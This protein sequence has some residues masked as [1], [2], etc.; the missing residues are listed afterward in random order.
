VRKGRLGAAARR[1]LDFTDGIDRAIPV[2]EALDRFHGAITPFN[3]LNT[4]A[5]S[6][7]LSS[8]PPHRCGEFTEGV[9][10]SKVERSHRTHR[11][12]NRKLLATMRITH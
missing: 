4:L 5:L 6:T 9:E 12:A 2:P 10:I 7:F 11:E 8:L 1:A 3:S